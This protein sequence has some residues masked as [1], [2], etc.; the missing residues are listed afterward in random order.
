MKKIIRDHFIREK[1]RATMTLEEKEKD[2]EQECEKFRIE[3]RSFNLIG[4]L[5]LSEFIP[6][7]MYLSVK[8]RVYF[9]LKY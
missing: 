6:H 7:F 4:V 9:S 8:D 2:H 1:R 3:E 5:S